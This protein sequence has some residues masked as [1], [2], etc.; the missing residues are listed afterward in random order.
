[1]SIL[2][3]SS[4][5]R[6]IIV[7][8]RPSA[9]WT[10]YSNGDKNKLGPLPKIYWAQVPGNKCVGFITVHPKGSRLDVAVMLPGEA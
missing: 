5:V 6:D 3:G 7:K 2:L 1:M 8:N 9:L 10:L 4:V